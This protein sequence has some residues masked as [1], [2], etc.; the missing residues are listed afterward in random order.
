MR[1]A[2]SNAQGVPPPVHIPGTVSSW[3][4]GPPLT[5]TCQPVPASPDGPKE[6]ITVRRITKAVLTLA[7]AVSGA[8]ALAGGG[9][10]PSVGVA[11]LAEH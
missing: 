3:P 1:R 6:E 5:A 9:R 11:L 7:A 10:G 8:T 2:R 4:C